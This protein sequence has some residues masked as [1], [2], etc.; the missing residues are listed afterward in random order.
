MGGGEWR[1]GTTS[2]ADIMQTE[3]HQGE[4]T[5]G[6][7]PVLNRPDHQVVSVDVKLH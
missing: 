5:H 3:K 7:V 4:R 2:Q 6:S 1:G